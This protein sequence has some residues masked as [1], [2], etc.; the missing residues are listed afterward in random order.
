MTH[1]LEF[2]DVTTLQELC[3]LTDAV[4]QEEPSVVHV[5][6]RAIVFHTPSQRAAFLIALDLAADVWEDAN[7]HG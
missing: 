5:N 7:N 1:T 4:W 3:A 2:P 6:D